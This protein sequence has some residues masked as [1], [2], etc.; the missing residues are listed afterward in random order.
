MA[1]MAS[2]TDPITWGLAVV[3]ECQQAEREKGRRPRLTLEHV[4]PDEV[5]Q[6]K[7]SVLIAE[8]SSSER[9][10]LDDSSRRLTMNL[11][12]VGEGVLEAGDDRVDIVLAHLADVL[13][14]EGHGLQATVA[15]VQLGCAVLV[16]DGGNAGEGSTGLSNDGCGGAEK[17]ASGRRSATRRLTDGDGTADTRLT[18]LHPQV[19]EQ[20]TQHILRSD[21]LGDVT[22]RV[23]GSTTNGLLVRLEQVEQLETDAHP[24]ASGDE[25]GSTIGDTSDEVNGSLLHLLVSIAE[26]GRHARDC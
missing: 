5:H 19:G 3:R 15:D 24:L 13:E 16:E 2:R 18:L 8:S 1:S 22:E 14:Q 6:V 23:D 7:V 26:N 21:S 20:N 4:R 25:L 17:S 9:E 12:S 10:M 11:V